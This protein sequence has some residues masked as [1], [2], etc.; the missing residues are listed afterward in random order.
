[1]KGAKSG[2]TKTK[3]SLGVCSKR[4]LSAGF[5][6]ALSCFVVW[7]LACYYIILQKGARRLPDDSPG[8]LI[9]LLTVPRKGN[10]NYLN[11]TLASIE[12]EH[13]MMERFFGHVHILSS[14][15]R[16]QHS[17]WSETAAQFRYNPIFEF[18]TVT[19]CEMVPKNQPP[20]QGRWRK[21]VP[22][23]IQ[24]NIDVQAWLGETHKMCSGKIPST[25]TR[26]KGRYEYVMIM[27]DDFTW[28]PSAG[29]HVVHAMATLQEHLPS[30][31]SAFRLSYGLNGIVL[32]CDDI[33]PM[34]KWLRSQERDGPAD[35]LAAEFY[36]KEVPEGR[37]HFGGG[38]QMYTYRYN[39]MDHQGAITSLGGGQRTS[40]D[41]GGYRHPGCFDVLASNGFTIKRESFDMNVCAPHEFY[42][43]DFLSDEIG[44]K[45]HTPEAPSHLL[46][47]KPSSRVPIASPVFIERGQNEMFTL[48]WKPSKRGDD[49]E[50][51]CKDLGERYQCS[52]ELMQVG[53]DCSLMRRAFGCSAGC[54]PSYVS[55]NMMEAGAHCPSFNNDTGI[56][57]LC[58]RSRAMTCFQF[59]KGWSRLCA[60]VGSNN[61]DQD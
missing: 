50:S 46:D 1:M 2:S 39:L 25:R 15:L 19:P 23:D 35:V 30:R 11:A 22:S 38:R 14:S 4:G 27:E 26:G 16:E 51:T 49:C 33:P 17:A 60:C 34:I 59:T 48:V 56:C 43:C 36:A 10:V 28:C 52:Q 42:P 31:F 47:Q 21:M 45:H 40:G 5:T 8:L 37:T 61:Q 32:L 55:Q 29:T 7:V 20:H 12:H 53:N 18:R 6:V 57:D 24:Q 3:Q 13:Y 9:T 58:S 41:M 54:M 44:H